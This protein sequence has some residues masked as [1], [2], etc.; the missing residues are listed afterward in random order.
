MLEHTQLLQQPMNLK[1]V[2][3]ANP[4]F[5]DP[6]ICRQNQAMEMNMGMY[7]IMCCCKCLPEVANP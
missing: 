5:C 6:I 2:N 7:M 1:R 3:T 4:V